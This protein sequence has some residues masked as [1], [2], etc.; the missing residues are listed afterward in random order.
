MRSA[1]THE[2]RFAMR[3]VNVVP[4]NPS[5]VHVDVVCHSRFCCSDASTADGTAGI[6]AGLLDIS[7]RRPAEKKSRSN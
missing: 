2:Q 6:M 4:F 5:Y 3:F 7:F 1:C